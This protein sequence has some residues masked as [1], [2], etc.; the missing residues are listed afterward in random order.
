[1]NRAGALLWGLALACS[2]PAFAEDVGVLP[3]DALVTT[4]KR[5]A[6]STLAPGIRVA[7][8]W[9]LASSD[10][11]FGGASGLMLRDTV[12][13][14]LTDSGRLFDLEGGQPVRSR[15]LP[16]ACARPGGKSKADAEAMTVSPDGTG[17]QVALERV[18]MVC[19]WRPD[20]PEAAVLS[21][22]SAMRSWK[23]NRGAEAMAN[24]PGKG[25]LII[26]EGAD[27]A[28]GQRPL[29]W[30]HGDPAN[31]STAMTTMRYLP[32]E[33]FK[34]GDAAF[35]PDG[36]LIVLNRQTRFG[37]QAAT[38]L[39]I[40]EAFAPQEQALLTGREL[41]R[42]ENSAEAANYEG[43]AIEPHE[44]RTTIWLV[45]DNNFR[46]NVETRLLRLELTD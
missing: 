22:V 18:N 15:A 25:T 23:R 33:G 5:V 45:S 9:R 30:Y 1:M 21:P 27:T 28:D 6:P 3:E 40:H 16:P 7:G 8:S 2:V 34:P 32:P 11:D 29:L 39:T 17:L 38:V 37:K 42:I 13:T 26:G 46:A 24:L 41:A 35:L 4:E 10:Q 19:S 44:G 14:I 12:L 31:P 36:R 43:M 20:A